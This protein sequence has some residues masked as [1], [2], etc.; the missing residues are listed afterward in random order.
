MLQSRTTLE[1]KK[2]NV[3]ETVNTC[4][5]VH[6]VA[7]NNMEEDKSHR[8]EEDDDSSKREKADSE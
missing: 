3:S 5:K 8:E 2:I 7:Y 4:A 1:A 6:N